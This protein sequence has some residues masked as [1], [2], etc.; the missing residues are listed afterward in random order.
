MR[1]QKQKTKALVCAPALSLRARA[2]GTTLGRREA[3]VWGGGGGPQPPRERQ[4]LSTA[5][6]PAPGRC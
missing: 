1:G 4:E 2:E 6:A 3:P 5:A